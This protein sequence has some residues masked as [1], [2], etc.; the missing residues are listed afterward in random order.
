MRAAT[1]KTVAR[2]SSPSERPLGEKPV[3][4]SLGRDNE[5]GEALVKMN[6]TGHV[7]A[8]M[9]CVLAGCASTGERIDVAIPGSATS[10]A[11]SG[12]SGTGL[13]V[14]VTPFDDARSDRSHLG[15][16]AHFWGGTSTFDLP[17]GTVGEAV[18]RAMVQHLNKRGWQAS[19][20]GQAGA[21]QP[22]ATISGS[23]QDLSV[24]AVSKFGRTELAAKSTIM[25][26]VA[27]HDDEST[28]Q[29]RV[30]GSGNNEV[31]WFGPEDAEALINELVDKNI[32]KFLADTKVEGR[33][34]KLR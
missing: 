26:H 27:N 30:L 8:V 34:V 23:I 16:R 25:V 6:R 17:K 12:T 29:E 1:R 9:L 7:A 11:S 2:I 32:E 21:S 19:L 10:P 24:N 14:A 20:A 3:Y 15:S 28:I 5:K 4:P 31:F 18:A 22:D 33:T 13:R